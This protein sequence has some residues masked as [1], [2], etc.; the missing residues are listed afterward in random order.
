MNK[1]LAPILA[2]AGSVALGASSA[3]ADAPFRWTG[4][5]VGA[6]I[7]ADWAHEGRVNDAP[8]DAA[9][10][11][12]ANACLVA[13]ACPL[14]LKGDTGVG[15]LA[16]LQ[17]G[18][19]WQSSNFVFGIEVDF[20]LSSARTKHISSV[21]AGGGFLAYQAQ[22]K[23]D[24]DWFSTARLRAGVLVT[25]TMLAY[26]TGGVAFGG[27]ERFYQNTF[28][29][30]AGVLTAPTNGTDKSTEIGWTA[31]GGFEWAVSRGIT[32]GIEYLH[33]NLGGGTVHATFIPGAPGGCNAA[34]C[35][36]TARVPDLDQDIVRAKLNF[37]Y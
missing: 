31:G 13:N 21:P 26:A 3:Q 20:Q 4:F 10:L 9:S 2:L 6:N 28:L 7:G 37:K 5:Y 27:V 34:N 1:L 23:T 16:G 17:G 25:P 12:F 33:V 29:S 8:A 35:N 24:V 11:A 30:A 32:L 36:Y 18:Y 22:E 15:A 19:N 14:G